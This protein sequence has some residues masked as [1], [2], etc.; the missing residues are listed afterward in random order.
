MA[1]NNF[2]RNYFW[3]FELKLSSTKTY[4]LELIK[5]LLLFKNAFNLTHT[6]MFVVI[7][8]LRKYSKCQTNRKD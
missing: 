8:L 5:I 3:D 7:I 4:F 6:S 1:G 2:L